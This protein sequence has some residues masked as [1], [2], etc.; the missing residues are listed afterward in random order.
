MA[1][2]FLANCQTNFQGMMNVAQWPKDDLHQGTSRFD[3]SRVY[4][5]IDLPHVSDL[6][7]GLLMAASPFVSVTGKVCNP[8]GK[9]IIRGRTSSAYS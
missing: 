3:P 5:Y 8:P 6:G 7:R 1:S 2:V 4:Q 9:N